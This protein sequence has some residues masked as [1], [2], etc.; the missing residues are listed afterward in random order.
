MPSFSQTGLADSKVLNGSYRA[1]RS[2]G[3]QPDL[4]NG[5]TFTVL[6]GKGENLVVTVHP[7]V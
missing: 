2:L 3:F 6:L 5:F 1:L 7:G 4:P